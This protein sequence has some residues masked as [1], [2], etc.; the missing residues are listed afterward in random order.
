MH[1]GEIYG[2]GIVGIFIPSGFVKYIPNV[3]YVPDLTKILIYVTQVNDVSY[4]F[5]FAPHKCVTRTCI[6]KYKYPKKNKK[7]SKL[8]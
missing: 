3:L 1:L 4:T 2:V 6:L 7:L 8:P 5:I